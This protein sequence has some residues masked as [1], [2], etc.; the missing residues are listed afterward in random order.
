MTASTRV[1]VDNIDVTHKCY[2]ADV[3]RGIAYCYA[4]DTDGKPKT[5]NN[6]PVRIELH[7]NVTVM[8][9]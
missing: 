4:V 2:A 1:F 6:N 8:V 3:E 7:G 5:M 9:D